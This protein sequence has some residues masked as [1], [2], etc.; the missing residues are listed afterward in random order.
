[1]KPHRTRIRPS[2]PSSHRVVFLLSSRI[3]LTQGL[4]GLEHHR[5]PDDTLQMLSNLHFRRLLAR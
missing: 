3:L 1:M 4:L 5:R 2:R